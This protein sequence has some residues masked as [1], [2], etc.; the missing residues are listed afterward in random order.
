MS[1]KASSTIGFERRF[2]AAL[3]IEREGLRGRV[4]LG[5]GAE[6]SEHDPALVGSTAAPTSRQPSEVV[7]LPAVP[8]GATVLDVRPARSYLAGHAG[9]LNVPVSGTSFATK[10]GFVLDPGLPLVVQ[11]ASADEA[12][13]AVRGLRSIGFLELEG[14]VLGGGHER[15]EAVGLDELEELLKGEPS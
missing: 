4:G 11:A 10:A 7:E 12:G 14:Y 13:R 6:A 3:Q 1:S 8:V 2:N 9:A 5:V 15:I